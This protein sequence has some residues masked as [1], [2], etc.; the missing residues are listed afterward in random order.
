[1]CEYFF[2]IRVEV[3]DFKTFSKDKELFKIKKKNLEI[4]FFQGTG[5]IFD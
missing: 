4:I 3:S 2:F 5:P 1:M